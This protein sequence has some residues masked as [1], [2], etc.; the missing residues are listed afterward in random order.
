MMP[1]FAPSFHREPKSCYADDTLVLVAVDDW[2]NACCA[3]ERVVGSVTKL[4]LE[5]C[6]SGNWNVCLSITGSVGDLLL[7]PGRIS[8]RGDSYDQISR[9]HP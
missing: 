1:S 7:G 5:K 3:T 2:G 9:T 4:G 6:L 8:P